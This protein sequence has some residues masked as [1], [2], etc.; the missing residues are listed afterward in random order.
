MANK[1]N[2]SK[3]LVVCPKALQ[4]N[5]YNEIK[6]WADKNSVG[7][8][9]G[10]YQNRSATLDEDFNWYIVNYAM[11]RPVKKNNK[12]L[13]KY[14][15]L[16]SREWDLII[17]DESQ[18]LMGRKS[19]QTRGA[20]KLKCEYLIELTGTPILTKPDQLWS[21]LNIIDNKKFSSYWAFVEEYL[22]TTMNPF[23]P[24]TPLI[25]GVKDKEKFKDML[26]NHMIRT[27]KEE[28]LP[29]LP[30]KIYKTVPITL[31]G[32]QKKLYTQLEKEMVLECDKDM[33][34][35]G[36]VLEQQLRLR[37]LCLDPKIVI[38]DT[39]AKSIKTEMILNYL[40]NIEDQAVIFTSFKSYA[41]ILYE[42]LNS[43]KKFKGKVGLFTGD[44][45]DSERERI[46]REFKKGNLLLFLGTIKAGGVGLNLQTASELIFTDKDWSPKIN[47][48]VEDR[49]HRFG[50]VKS[51]IITSFVCENTVESDLEKVLSKR[52]DMI[53]SVI[54]SSNI[55]EEQRRRCT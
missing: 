19:Q 34:K 32:T 15:Q 25:T 33:L 46:I 42:A 50:Q 52:N 22:S 13:P 49:V 9:T 27:T 39:K 3:I 28:V 17:F 21:Q 48:Q 24:R 20:K 11:L 23:S 31:E 6:K 4:V 55:L 54:V 36:T 7:V 41:N 47:E 53:N 35:V 38:P 16:T 1:I 18:N 30:P 44:T 14:P 5:W 29:E 26:S 12:W 40:D 37:Q 45:P 43:T 8:C 2:A 51:P 10:T